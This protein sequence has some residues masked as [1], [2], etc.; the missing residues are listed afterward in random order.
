MS[1]VTVVGLSLIAALPTVAPDGGRP[2]PRGVQDG[3]L[4]ACASINKVGE[5]QSSTKQSPIQVAHWGAKGPPVVLVHEGVQGT[6]MGGAAQFAPQRQLV[7]RGWQMMVPDR[8]G[9]GQSASRGP[10]DMV[11]DAQW[12]AQ[13]LGDGAHLVGHSFGGGIA[14]I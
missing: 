13:M 5:T 2:S 1:I 11:A 14:L 8:P 3:L 10:D 4:A 9:H 7:E 6:R 12:V